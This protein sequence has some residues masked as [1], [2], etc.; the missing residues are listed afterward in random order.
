MKI[1]GTS[2][3]NFKLIF[4]KK[5]DRSEFCPIFLFWIGKIRT[6]LKTFR[7]TDNIS[8]GSVITLFLEH[9]KKMEPVS[10]TT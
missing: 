5:W 4:R 6:F 1:K 7:N 10:L 9:L 8:I 2:E 3:K